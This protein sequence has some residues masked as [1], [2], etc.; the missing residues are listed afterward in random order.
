MELAI[1]CYKSWL[2]LDLK[3]RCSQGSIAL[4]FGLSKTTLH[5]HI[6]G[7]HTSA[8]V[9]SEHLQV[10]TKAEEE[11]LVLWIRCMSVS[12]QPPPH[13]TGRETFKQLI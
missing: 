6:N 13:S 5:N 3:I 11:C 1:A 4:R 9:A 7:C 2:H 10:L 12:G 8:K